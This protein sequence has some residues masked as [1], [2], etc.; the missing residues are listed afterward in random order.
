M[1]PEQIELARHALGLPNKRRMSYRNRFVAG[2]GHTD[3]LH[4]IQMV[5]DGH[6]KRRDG[7][8]SALTGGADFFWLTTAGACQALQ[9]RET[10]DPEHF[11]GAKR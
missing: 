9:A 4:W 5:T 8:K 10:F 7:S 1:K 6:A 11:P 3:Y 2:P